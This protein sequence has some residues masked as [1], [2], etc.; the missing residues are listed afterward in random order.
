ML[1]ENLATGK[2]FHPEGRAVCAM[3]DLNLEFLRALSAE[4]LRLSLSDRLRMTKFPRVIGSI[5]RE[6]NAAR[7]T[8]GN[9]R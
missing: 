9:S 6:S 8:S 3:K 1:F 4:I 2:I 7:P 5:L